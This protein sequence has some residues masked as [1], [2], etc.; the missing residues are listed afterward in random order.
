[1]DDLF[2]EHLD[3]FE[4]RREQTESLHIENIRRFDSIEETLRVQNKMLATI[5]DTGRA[6]E[7]QVKWT[8]GQ[9]RDLQQWK[10][11]ITGGLA[12]LTLLVVPVVI[13]FV[14]HAGT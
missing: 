3:G 8:N 1:M 10:S 7:T 4:R 14:I 12:V 13:Y 9:V 11:F 6:T 5:V 2:K